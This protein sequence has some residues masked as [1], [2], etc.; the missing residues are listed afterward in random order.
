MVLPFPPSFPHR[1]NTDGSFD[2]ICLKCLLTVAN[3]R[4]EA[5]LTE[6]EQYHV[7]IPPINFQRLSTA[8]METGST[9]HEISR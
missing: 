2:S 8:L 1:R 6:H 5:D 9:S 3:A 4:N 7:S